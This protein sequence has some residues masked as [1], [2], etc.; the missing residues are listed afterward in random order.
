MK[1]LS[2]GIFTIFILMFSIISIGQS[3]SLIGNV[4]AEAKLID[5]HNVELYLT[6]QDDSISISDYV[7]IKKN[8]LEIQPT[9]F[10][11]DDPLNDSVS[12]SDSVILAKHIF[13]YDSSFKTTAILD[14]IL[15]KTKLSKFTNTSY[16]SFNELI[17]ND[18]LQTQQNKIVTSQSQQTDLSLVEL[19]NI[20]NNDLRFENEIIFSTSMENSEFILPVLL[21]APLFSLILVKSNNQQIRSSIPQKSIVYFLIIV[22]VSSTI[23]TPLA[24]SNNYWGYAFAEEMDNSTVDVEPIQEFNESVEVSF[25][26]QTSAETTE[27]EPVTP[28][29]TIEEIIAEMIEEQALKEVTMESANATSTEPIDLVNATSTEPID[30]VNATSTEPII[31]PEATVSFQFDNS[32]PETSTETTESE[33][34]STTLVLDGQGDF[35]QIANV[36]TINDLDGLTVTVWVKPDYSSGSPEFT[37]LS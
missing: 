24:I 26:S 1:K 36:T 3:T 15:L 32:E 16:L 30:L 2:I 14:R 9:I 31:I 21:I 8:N 20:L 27:P 17:F 12:I 7:S 13:V 10:D 22:L 25:S 19:S 5:S 18:L 11:T 29:Q 37:V 6:Q 33:P 4:D 35:L 28:E 34:E 23:S